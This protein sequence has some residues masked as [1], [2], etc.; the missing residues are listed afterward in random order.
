MLR[1]NTRSLAGSQSFHMS[2]EIH[3]VAEFWKNLLLQVDYPS[4]LKPSA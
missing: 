2:P 1:G 3:I 4:N